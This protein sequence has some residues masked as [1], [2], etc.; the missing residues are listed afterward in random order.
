[1]Q[2]VR[3]STQ[4]LLWAA[5]LGQVLLLLAFCSK[6]QRETL[7]ALSHLRDELATQFSQPPPV[8]SILNRRALT[9]GFED[10]FSGLSAAEQQAKAREVAAFAIDHYRAVAVEGVTVGFAQHHGPRFLNITSARWFSFK[11][12]DLRAEPVPSPTATAR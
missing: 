9:I 10:A 5:G 8:V 7:G 4:G 12:S 3:R 2:S 6:G 11:V 1:M